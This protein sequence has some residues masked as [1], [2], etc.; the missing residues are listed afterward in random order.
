M[1]S[2]ASKLGDHVV[3]GEIKGDRFR[4]RKALHYRNSFQAELTLRFAPVETGTRIEGSFADPV[5]ARWFFPLWLGFA[6]LAWVYG[7]FLLVFVALRDSANLGK[8]APGLVIPSLLLIGG[9]CMR[10][11]GRRFA[12]N[13]PEFL[14]RFLVHVLEAEVVSA[15]APERDG[16]RRQL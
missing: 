1:P 2:L 16:G 10:V 4:L 6:G 15:P 11:V 14:T 9:I 5:F 3:A 8:V 12:R 13:E 7:T